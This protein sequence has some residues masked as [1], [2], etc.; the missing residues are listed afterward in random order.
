MTSYAQSLIE[1]GARAAFEE[2]CRS[3]N[4]G[5]TLS[6]GQADEWTRRDRRAETRACLTAV[7]AALM[8]PPD[9]MADKGESS[10]ICG[11][12]PGDLE[13]SP[14]PTWAHAKSCWRAML[15]AFQRDLAAPESDNG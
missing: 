15:K 11:P 9:A 7:I 8:E 1:A 6:W 13:A 14:S 10:L 4:L 3:A 5:D 2:S 12:D